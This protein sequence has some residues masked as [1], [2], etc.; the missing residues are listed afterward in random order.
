MIDDTNIKSYLRGLLNFLKESDIIFTPKELSAPNKYTVFMDSTHK[1]ITGIR[2]SGIR[3][4]LKEH[5]ECDEY[6]Y[7][8]DSIEHI[9]VENDAGKLSH[10]YFSFHFDNLPEITDSPYKMFRLDFKPNNP[11]TPLHAHD[12]QYTQT[13]SH[14]VYP[15]DIQLNLNKIDLLTTLTILQYYFYHPE[16]YPLDNQC[17]ANYNKILDTTRRPYII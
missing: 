1:R 9:T 6:H 5:W 15:S 13:N 12:Y 17:A 4:K 2:I 8:L 11:L 16:N 10:E 14:L 7:F 3:I